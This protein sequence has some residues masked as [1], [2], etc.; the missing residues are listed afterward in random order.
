MPENDRILLATALVLGTMVLGLVNAVLILV[1]RKYR[2]DID[3][4]TPFWQGESRLHEFNY[5][6][7]NNYTKEGV[8][9]LYVIYVISL[10]IILL[11]AV[12]LPRILGV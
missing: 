5:L 9:V 6:N 3:N 2:T 11:F 12:I 7:P 8:R 10:W 1:I 4:R